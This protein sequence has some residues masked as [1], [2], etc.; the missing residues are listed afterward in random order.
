MNPSLV[1]F[2]LALSRIAAIGYHRSVMAFN[3][4]GAPLYGS[5]APVSPSGEGGTARSPLIG[6]SSVVR[7]HRMQLHRTNRRPTTPERLYSKHV[8][9]LKY[10]ARRKALR[11]ARRLAQL[12]LALEQES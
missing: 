10:A 4:V 3:L 1:A 11:Q 9:N 5:V 2:N 7:A 6:R 12:A 8:Y